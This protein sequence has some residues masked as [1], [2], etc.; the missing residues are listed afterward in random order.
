[1]STIKKFDYEGRSFEIR[2]GT[3]GDSWLLKVFI[4]GTPT[5][6]DGSVSH[7]IQND[8]TDYDIG[9][10]RQIIADALE[11]HIKNGTN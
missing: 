8:S 4:D 7:E 9:D 2:M 3:D 10:P 5:K 1:L 6:V 11:K